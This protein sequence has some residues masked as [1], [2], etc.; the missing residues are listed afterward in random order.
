M[1]KVWLT[2]AWKDNEDEDVNFVISQ[3]K[4]SGLD[5]MYDRRQII[6]G[7]RIWPQIDSLISKTSVD[8]WVYYVTENSLKSQPCI[9]EL[10][11]ALHEALSARGE[12]F[13]LIGLIPSHYDMQ[14][15]PKALSTRLCVSLRES[16]WLGRIVAGVNREVPPEPELNELK[17]G[18]KLHSGDMGL[19]L[20][21]WPRT[22]TWSPVFAA[23]LENERDSMKYIL[24]GNRNMITGM[25]KS[26]RSA[27]VEIAGYA[28][29]T[30]DDPV[31]ADR[32]LHIYLNRLPSQMIFGGF[33]AGK[34]F[35]GKIDFRGGK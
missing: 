17:Y 24:P 21:V 28:S 26:T 20:E 15:L 6:P 9:E 18:H 25:G 7:Q 34:E 23:V 8:A 14:L 13:P 19:V 27:E 35:V 2:Y 33:V 1:K 29:Q 12:G 30:F 4:A 32:T 10:N 22:G 3:L 5:V 16:D 11:Y 31:T